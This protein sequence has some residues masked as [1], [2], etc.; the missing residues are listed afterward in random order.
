MVGFLGKWLVLL[1]RPGLCRWVWRW[2]VVVALSRIVAIGE[3]YQKKKKRG[4]KGE[5]ERFV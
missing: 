1:L 4:E 5:K 3:G 2:V